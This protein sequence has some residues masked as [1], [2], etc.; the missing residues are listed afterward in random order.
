MRAD[1]TRR[2]T[3][4]EA[5]VADQRR[6]E[7]EIVAAREQHVTATEAFNAIQS[8]HYAVQSEISRLEQAIAHA[9]EM[10]DRQLG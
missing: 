5:A 4:F 9:R 3:E 2:Q 8:Q 1:L 6:I 7:A 10:R